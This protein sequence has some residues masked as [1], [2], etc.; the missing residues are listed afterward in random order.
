LACGA[1][2]GREPPAGTWLG[3]LGAAAAGLRERSDLPAAVLAT[4]PALW[5]DA[6]L[7]AVPAI[8]YDPGGVAAGL[9]LLFAPRHP[10][11]GAP[12]VAG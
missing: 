2:P 6:A 3:A 4:L 12:F 10:A 1:D 8:G 9:G 5:G 11:A 7:P